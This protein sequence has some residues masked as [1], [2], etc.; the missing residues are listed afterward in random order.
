MEEALAAEERRIAE[1]RM[2]Q[3]DS[4][5]MSPAQLEALKALGY[6]GESAAPPSN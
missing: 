6:V 3:A 4:R 5:A 1:G 2:C